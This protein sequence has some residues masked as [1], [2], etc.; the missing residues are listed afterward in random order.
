MEIEKNFKK[1]NYKII[2]RYI[3]DCN[4]S[5]LRYIING[6]HLLSYIYETNNYIY[7]PSVINSIIR[8]YIFNK[9]YFSSIKYSC[10]YSYNYKKI[11]RYINN[12][13]L[14]DLSCI[15]YGYHLLSYIYEA[16]KYIYLPSVI[17]SIIR[18]YIHDYCNY[19]IELTGSFYHINVRPLYS[20]D[21]KYQNKLNICNDI[22]LNKKK[23]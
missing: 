8:N 23:E 13:N 22:N 10:H 9:N 1:Y 2:L 20:K 4:L 7:I 17:N 12:C 14:S 6:Y 3:N 11:P 16:N 15:I 19:M 5:D 18:N 21:I